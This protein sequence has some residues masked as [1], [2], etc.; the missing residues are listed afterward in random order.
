MWLW[1]MPS[2]S[3]ALSAI[4]GLLEIALKKASGATFPIIAVLI[5][6]TILAAC[7]DNKVVNPGTNSTPNILLII[8]DDMGLD[9]TPGYNVGT[10]KPSMPV[11]QDLSANGIVFDN[12]WSNPLCS[13]TRATIL[14]GK[15]GIR[16]GVV[17]AS[18]PNN[19]I[20]LSET[21]L[22]SYLAQNTSYKSAV[23][24]KWHL[25][26]NANGGADNPNLMGVEY[27]AGL[28]S[29]GHDDYSDWSFTQNGQTSTV[30]EYSTT[31]FTNLAIDWID[32]QQS[33]WFLWLAYTAP[34][35]PFHLPPVAL[36]SVD[37][38]SGDTADIDANPRS[39]YFAMLEALDTE[40]GRLLN[41]ID[42]ENTIIIFIG[43]NGSPAR[44]VQQPYTRTRAKGTVYQ[45]GIHV[46]MVIS[47]SGV[48]R[49][50]QREAALINSA[51]LFATIADLAGTG[52]ESIHDSKSFKNLLNSGQSEER[53]FIYSEV[54]ENVTAWA[55][56]NEKY[57][58][59]DFQNGIQE[60]YDLAA[61]P[62]EQ[63]DLIISGLSSEDLQ[64]KTE[65]ESLADGVRNE[66]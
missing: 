63:N 15:Y 21:S 23:I 26:N 60:F 28:L 8:A 27:Y 50:G 62:Y 20:S 46:P 22:Q 35:T 14:T 16:T 51:D 6:F 37:N 25:S 66:D 44:V 24:V 2:K 49:S 3:E 19:A 52:L 18:P 5:V 42:I 56:R 7:K 54:Q 11:L 1:I 36:H 59:I 33:P 58:L 53:E 61:D 55:I 40:M 43:D 57:K 9:A 10:E 39:Y 48:T 38:L 64:A 65:L 30:Q 47:G 31:F 45:G 17:S 13:P 29:G 4:D 41:S 34:H 32:Q 12:V